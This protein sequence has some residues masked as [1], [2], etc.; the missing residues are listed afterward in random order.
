MAVEEGFAERMRRRGVR[1][2]DPGVAVAALLEVVGGDEGC[3]TV[4]DMDWPRFARAFTAVR[5][6]P[7]ISDIPE[8]VRW[9]ALAEREQ[10]RAQGVMR[11]AG[12]V[13]VWLN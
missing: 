3:V 5:P 7:L 12:C 10:P 1:G 9:R 13:G 2:M 6:S 11:W 8:V 4:T